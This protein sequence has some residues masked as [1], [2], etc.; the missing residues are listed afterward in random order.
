MAAALMASLGCGKNGT[1]DADTPGAAS[2]A[3]VAAPLEATSTTELVAL[4]GD[5]PV[6]TLVV[7]DEG[8]APMKA[9]MDAALPLAEIDRSLEGMTSTPMGA[10]MAV[11]E[12]LDVEVEGPPPSS[13]RDTSRP[14]VVGLFDVPSSGPP[15]TTITTLASADSELPPLRHQVVIPATDAAA[16]T[17]ALQSWMGTGAQDM[18]TL[19]EGRAGAVGLRYH[20]DEPGNA[21]AI[22]PEG[23]RV[24]VVGLFG[25]S[26]VD[27]ATLAG[28]LDTESAPLPD[29]PAVRLAVDTSYPVTSL[30]RPW[31]LRA[32]ATWMGM[33]E[34]HR[35]VATV[36][37]D[38]R[39]AARLR[40]YSIAAVAEFLTP[41]EHA[42]FD[43]WAFAV[44][45]NEDTLHATSVVSLTP[46]GQQ[47]WKAG[48]AAPAQPLVVEDSGRGEAI[49][50]ADLNSM[51]AKAGT[52][53]L[54]EGGMAEVVEAV[55]N[56]GPM[57]PM[58]F[59]QRWPVAL[60]KTATFGGPTG[61][62]PS[63]TVSLQVAANV[64]TDTPKAALAIQSKTDLEPM[65]KAFPDF[66][67]DATVSKRG[68]DSVL[69]FNL[70]L[71]PKAVF[72]TDGGGPTPEPGT[73]G[74]LSIPP[75][76]PVHQPVR[77]TLR[78]SDTALIGQM[79]IGKGEFESPPVVAGL[80][81][82][83]PLRDAA[84]ADGDACLLD[85]VRGLRALGEV[86]R[87]VPDQRG[88][89]Y[90]EA[91]DTID[92]ATQ[93]ADGKPTAAS[94]GSL[95]QTV[96]LVVARSMVANLEL[97]GAK[98]LLKEACGGANKATPACATQRELRDFSMPDV[99]KHNMAASCSSD[100]YFGG[101]G[102]PLVVADDKVLLSTKAHPKDE[103]ALIEA[104]VELTPN[105]ARFE[106][107]GPTV[108]LIV[109]PATPFSEVV[110]L[111]S[112]LAAVNSNWHAVVE[113]DGKLRPLSPLVRTWPSTATVD[114]KVDPSQ[115][116]HDLYEEPPP[117]DEEPPPGEEGRMGK[118]RSGLYAMK[119]PKRSR[120]LWIELNET[121][122]VVTLSTGE[123]KTLTSIADIEKYVDLYPNGDAVLMVSGS[124]PWSRLIEMAV[125]ACG[126]TLELVPEGT[127]EIPTESAGELPSAGFGYGR[128]GIGFGR[129]GKKVPRIRQG[130]ST[131]KGSLDKDIIRRIVRA[132]INEVR[133]CYNDGLEKNPKLGGRVSVR[134]TIGDDGKVNNAK[135]AKTTL[136]DE[137]VG[138]CIAKAVDRWKFPKP[139]GGGSVAVTYPFVLEP[140]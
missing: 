133:A 73:I 53:T 71:D 85:A 2:A 123:K 46:T 49:V 20:A 35:A 101:F 87:A 9:R 77:A 64:G 11:T 47:I 59:A 79:V 125:A 44:R 19:V 122:V 111:F 18:P 121:D 107:S 61:A 130:K 14:I 94:I 76:G 69:M 43:D 86:S 40:G 82:A 32:F 103:A 119:G 3:P 120:D 102:T 93:C 98:A 96:R 55:R 23:D 54:P 92:K 126:M 110:P 118:P 25:A 112:P 45:G 38:Q 51:L 30:T 100:P 114:W 48:T 52:H 58:F 137:A 68:D 10:L 115:R 50:S 106:Q 12:L 16:L 70:G 97:D 72:D 63:E 83:S 89:L 22:I 37:L 75:A 108:A 29:T 135:V 95:A 13:G 1:D 4:V 134:F 33:Y 42:E 24:R 56:C 34:T 57:C 65:T 78:Y 116:P 62:I 90:R 129:K 113:I 88:Q 5:R 80:S 109:P 67:R 28:F 132:H 128:G 124:T 138:K 91:F 136:S 21:V 117:D 26:A 127:V 84:P 15:G 17:R 139:I 8:W 66:F 7:R 31:R 81:W 104:L 74:T 36:A 140:G 27:D 99:P 6:M 39:E 105:Y 60:A 131:V 41:D